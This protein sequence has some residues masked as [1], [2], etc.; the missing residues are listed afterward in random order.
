MKEQRKNEK[1]IILFTDLI[2]LNFQ[3]EKLIEKNVE[4]L[5]GDKDIIFLLIGKV[6]NKNLN[7][8]KNNITSNENTLED[9]ILSK[10]SEDSEIIYFEDIKRIKTILSNNTVIKDVIMYPNEIYK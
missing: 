7:N 9:L 6:K 5:I 4:N 10:F 1:Y 2:N 8:E 3:D